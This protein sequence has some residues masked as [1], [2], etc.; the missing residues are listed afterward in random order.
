MKCCVSTDVETWTN[1][2]TFE[3]DPDYSPDTGTGLLSPTSYGAATQNFITSGKSHVYLLGA[4]RCSDT[5][6]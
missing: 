2:L 3:P 5:W 1:C 4:R 6:F